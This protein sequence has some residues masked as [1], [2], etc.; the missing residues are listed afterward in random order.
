MGTLILIVLFFMAIFVAAWLIVE[1]GKRNAEKAKV[2]ELLYDLIQ[3]YLMKPV[4]D[5]NYDIITSWIQLLGQLKY[6]DM[7]RTEVLSCEFW[8]KYEKIRLERLSED[9]HSPESIFGK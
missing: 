4:T 8:R 3:E 2:Y 7:E 1:V 9:E 5:S 6:K